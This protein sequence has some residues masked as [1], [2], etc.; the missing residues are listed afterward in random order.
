[1]Q[2]KTVLDN[3][4]AGYRPRPLLTPCFFD[5]D[6]ADGIQAESLTEHVRKAHATR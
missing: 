3:S 4:I 5:C 1:M 2:A 6:L